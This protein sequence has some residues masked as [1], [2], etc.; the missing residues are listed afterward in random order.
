[1]MNSN[2]YKKKASDFQLLSL[3]GRDTES[4]VTLCK[5][6]KASQEQQDISCYLVFKQQTPHFYSLRKHRIN[7]SRF[8]GYDSVDENC[9]A[10]MSLLNDSAIEE[11]EVDFPLALYRFTN[12]HHI[13]N[14]LLSLKEHFEHNTLNIRL[15]LASIA[16]EQELEGI[17]KLCL[18]AGADNLT[19]SLDIKAKKEQDGY[20]SLVLK[21]LKRFFVT[22]SCGIIYSG[23]TTIPAMERIVAL[24]KEE[25][26][27]EWVETT[28]LKFEC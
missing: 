22:D 16:S 7:A 12:R 1:M 2:V 5:D 23:L 27:D 9:I 19:M 18:V 4:L 11:V 25:L 28:F 20:I 8:N 14:L 10:F 26:G 21:L 6:H 3:Q 17:T 13:F 24:S 15:P